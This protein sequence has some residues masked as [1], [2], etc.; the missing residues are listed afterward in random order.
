M[1][2]ACAHVQV[3]AHTRH[4]ARD[5]AHCHIVHTHTHAHAHVLHARAHQL[6]YS[7]RSA[8]RCKLP[9]PVCIVMASM[10]MLPAAVC[11]YRPAARPTRSEPD[12]LRLARSA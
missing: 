6:A 11:R 1:S 3:H 2:L 4:G 9:R 7:T 8:W 10:G 5:C 12:L